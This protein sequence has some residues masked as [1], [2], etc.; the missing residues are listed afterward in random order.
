[1]V[2]S[3][4]KFVIQYLRDFCLFGINFFFFSYN[5]FCLL[6]LKY[7]L[8]FNQT[9]LIESILIQKLLY[10]K[11]VFFL[12]ALLVVTLLS[13]PSFFRSQSSLCYPVYSPVIVQSSISF[14]F[15]FFNIIF[16]LFVFFIN[17]WFLF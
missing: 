1:M 5:S 2:F 9:V 13:S 6:F 12:C 3:V 8:F 4:L 7:S 17:Y 11:N 14:L 16:P 10:Q 15:S